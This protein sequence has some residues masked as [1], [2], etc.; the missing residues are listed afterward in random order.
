MAGWNQRNRKSDNFG[1]P[2]NLQQ[3]KLGEEGLAYVASCL[4]GELGL[5]SRLS[6]LLARGGDVFAPLPAG[7]SRER[8]LQFNAGG[9]MSLSETH[10][11]FAR[12]LEQLS[13]RTENG[14]LVFQDVWFRPEDPV[15]GGYDGVFFDQS[16]VYYVLGPHEINAAAI[17]R[18]MRRLRTFQLVAVFSSFTVRAMDVAPTRVVAETLIDEIA[19]GAQEVF[20]SAYDEE[21]LVVWRPKD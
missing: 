1:I 18:T 16:C 20:L 15:R 19:D 13:G 7:I 21:G 2:M 14:S 8:A 11:W 17:S 4:T 5:C 3:M 6:R 10:V 12:E 9:L